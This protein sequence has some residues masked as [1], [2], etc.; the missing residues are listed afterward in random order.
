MIRYQETVGGRGFGRAV[1]FA[2]GDRRPATRRRSGGGGVIAA[3][4]DDFAGIP[5]LRAGKKRRHSGRDDKL[6]GGE[7][8]L[9]SRFLCEQ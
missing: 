2:T 3:S 8:R 4:G 5:P 1:F 6:R 9:W 7:A